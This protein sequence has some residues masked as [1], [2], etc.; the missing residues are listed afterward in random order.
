MEVRAVVGETFSVRTD[1]VTIEEP[2]EIRI[3]FGPVAKREQKALAV[4]MRTPG[5]D[6]ELAAGFLL[7]EAIIAAPNDLV[8]V[9][10]AGPASGPGG[11]QNV[12]V[13]E[14]RPGATFH[15]GLVE[16]HFY[17]TSSCGVCGI[18]SLDAL[19]AR[20]A[21]STAPYPY[22]PV[23]PAAVV[24]ALPQRLREVQ[25]TF[26]TTGGLH[27]AA[28]FD[29]AGRLL[30]VREDV[31]RHNAVD[32]LIGA[33]VLAGRV[34]LTDHVLFLSGRVSFELVQKAAAAGVPVVAAVGAP[35]SLAIAAAERFGL[36]VLGF[37][38]DGRFNIYSGRE[39]IRD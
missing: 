26:N 28:L 14:L 33:E 34:P 5:H 24:H 29:V 8:A 18:T 20:F 22:S 31:G 7:S 3:V 9:R 25:R 13:V 27:A 19:E 30:S 23:I 16:R 10:A 1:A 11:G 6:E 4:T 12:V 39:R 36:T 37:V 38:R 35:S 17:T 15:P 2:L 32:K 21:T